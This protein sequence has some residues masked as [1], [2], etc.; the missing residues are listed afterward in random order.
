MILT[1]AAANAACD[2][3]VDLVDVGGAGY[4]E[5]WTASF[6]T[7]LATLTM[8]NPAFG[9]AVAGVAT[10]N[11]I[12]NDVSADNTGTAAVFKIFGGG[13]TECWRGTVG[14]TG[15]DMNFAAGVAFVALQIVGLSS[16]TATHPT[17]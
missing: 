4:V 15:A 13:G 12:A 8:S 7:K 11:A 16:M 10:A 6:V 3:I 9:S 1:T 14:V 5:I 17:T 2:A